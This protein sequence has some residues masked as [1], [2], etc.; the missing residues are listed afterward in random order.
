MEKKSKAHVVKEVVELGR[1]MESALKAAMLSKETVAVQDE[2]MESLQTI[3]T[4]MVEAVKAA[5]ESE[6]TEEVHQQ[7]KKVIKTSQTKGKETASAMRNNLT[8]GLRSISHQLA[9]LADDL[10]DN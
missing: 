8:K 5:R 7:V 3:G 6:K 2:F 10:D 1:R 9:R 4:K